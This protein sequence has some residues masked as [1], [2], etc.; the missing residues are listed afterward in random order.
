M[1]DIGPLVPI[2]ATRFPHVLDR[3]AHLWMRPEAVEAYLA[4]LLHAGP[5]GQHAFPMEAVGEVMLLR[6]VHIARLTQPGH[7]AALR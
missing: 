6:E 7:G 5:D 3:L 1:L 2:L 4:V